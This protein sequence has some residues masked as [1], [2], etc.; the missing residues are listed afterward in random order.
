MMW[1]M[2]NTEQANIQRRHFTKNNYWQTIASV[3][4]PLVLLL[5]IVRGPGETEALLIHIHNDWVYIIK[6]LTLNCCHGVLNLFS[7]TKPKQ[8]SLVTQRP[9]RLTYIT[10]L[11]V[12]VINNLIHRGIIQAE[13]VSICSSGPQQKQSL[14]ELLHLLWQMKLTTFEA[15]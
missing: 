10:V 5:F 15:S 12:T 6:L 4:V 7:I 14:S 13:D 8:L 1:N 9:H 3:S 2:T 11:I